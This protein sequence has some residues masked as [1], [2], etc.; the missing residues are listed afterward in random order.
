MG[1]VLRARRRRAQR[2]AQGEKPPAAGS[3][4]PSIG[5][6]INPKDLEICKRPDGSDWLLGEGAHGSVFKA[7]KVGRPL[8]AAADGKLCCAVLC[9][10]G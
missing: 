1:L 3:P 6:E 7:L 2:I 9:C 5:W 10:A 8:A 4:D